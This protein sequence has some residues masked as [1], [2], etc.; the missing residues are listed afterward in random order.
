MEYDLSFSKDQYGRYK[1]DQYQATLKSDAHPEQNKKQSFAVDAGHTTTATQALNLLEGRAVQQEYRN[2][3]GGRQTAW[4]KL[5]FNDKDNAGNY[6]RREYHSHTDLENTLEA[7][8][9]REKAN[10][11]EMEKLLQGLRNGER[12]AVHLQKHGKE[13][14]I[15]VEVNPS[16]KNV[17]LYNANGKKVGLQEALGEK[18]EKAPV[19][20][21][22]TTTEEKQQ[23]KASI[24]MNQ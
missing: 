12:V 21:L 19:V 22:P 14:P 24:A 20:S 6:K 11:A 4:I 7:L 9:I 2:A 1:L 13:I 18:K 17:D 10:H 8:P 16:L 23:R 3:L 5:D 15:S